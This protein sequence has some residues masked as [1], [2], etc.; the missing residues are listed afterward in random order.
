MRSLLPPLAVA[1]LLAFPPFVSAGEEKKDPPPIAVVAIDHK[2]PVVFE[3]EIEPILIN[4][5]AHCHSS[6]TKKEGRLD[7][8]G[9]DTMMRGGKSGPAI[10]P[11]KSADSLLCKLA[12]KTMKPLM[13]PKGE[14]PLTPQELAL[15]KLWVDQGAKPPSGT[16]TP[17]KVVLTA[18]PVSVHPVRGV[19]IS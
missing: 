19:A 15:I 12:G 4:K 16:R 11:G 18:P 9:Y 3:K 7:L 5:C 1:A 14:D 6:S 8:G 13:P 10:V 17:V 2:E